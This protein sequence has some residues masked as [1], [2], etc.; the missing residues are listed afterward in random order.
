[1]NPLRLK[2][3]LTALAAATMLHVAA[4]AGFAEEGGPPPALVKTSKVVVGQVR[5]TAE[6]IG[7]VFYQEV[8][9]VAAE[10]NGLV[11]V[12][13]FEDGQRVESG[14]SLVELKAVTLR[15]E[16]DAAR[17]YHEQAL[18]DLEIARI[19]LARKE[20]LFKRNSIAEQQYDE[21]RFRVKA[22]EKRAAAL[23]AEVERLEIELDKTVIRAP[24]SGAILERRVDR[25]EWLSEGETV[26]VLGKDD[27]IDVVAE[28]PER[29]IPYIAAGMQVQMTVN[30]RSFSGTVI[31]VVPRGDAATRNFPVKIRCP[32]PWGLIEGMSARVTLPTGEP[33]Q[34]LLVPRDA[35]ISQFGQNVVF[36]V[37]DSRVRMLPVQVTGY[38]G[39]TAGVLAE[40]LEAGMSV[41]TR[42]NE[43]LR[44]G[45][46]ITLDRG[47]GS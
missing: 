37:D 46:R 9:E 34:S 23:Q 19:D 2:S 26:A 13:R 21:N 38:D 18:A 17:A 8:S 7:T 20:K 43:R 33:R 31:A 42:G 6:F 24:F 41:V 15:K 4:G 3:T 45:Q 1:M 30:E 22:L 27:V 39:L 32:N 35:V 10:I 5:P 25:G 47:G 14:R 29:F 36:V 11:E 28:I 44:D 12:V 40:A 16:L